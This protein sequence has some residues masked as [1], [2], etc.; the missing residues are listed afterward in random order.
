M[1]TRRPP[2]T[3]TH[4]QT[5][6]T[7][8]QTPPDSPPTVT[9]SEEWSACGGVVVKDREEKWTLGRGDSAA[10][11]ICIAQLSRWV[12]NVL[13]YIPIKKKKQCVKVSCRFCFV[14]GFPAGRTFGRGGAP[15]ALL[16]PKLLKVTLCLY[17]WAIRFIGP[18]LH[19]L[20]A[21]CSPVSA[22]SAHSFVCHLQGYSYSIRPAGPAER[23]FGPS[24]DLD[25]GPKEG[26]EC[27]WCPSGLHADESCSYASFL[28]SALHSLRPLWEKYCQSKN[29]F[30]SH[31]TESAHIPSHHYSHSVWGC[32][33]TQ[34]SLL[35]Y[36]GPN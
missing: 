5:L 33:S 30:H 16:Q 4:I 20:E 11:K 14:Q 8:M 27:R 9:T 28:P 23:L 10:L 36:S 7:N 24:W 2:P 22:V 19:S 1:H 25:V 18:H 35:S 29:V 17:T 31:V 3:H 34:S 21:G 32:K 26:S 15:V 6:K 13:I 12:T